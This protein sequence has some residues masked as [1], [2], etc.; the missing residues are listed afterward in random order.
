MRQGFDSADRENH[1]DSLNLRGEVI[2]FVAR[3]DNTSRELGVVLVR[4]GVSSM[5]SASFG[6]Y[7]AEVFCRVL[8]RQTCAGNPTV[9]LPSP[10]GTVKSGRQSDTPSLPPS[11]I[12]RA[13]L[14]LYAGCVSGCLGKR[15]IHSVSESHERTKQ[16]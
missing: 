16:R 13:I 5:D 9:W 4:G 10:Y 15:E 14:V 6:L 3:D 1:V 7:E 12:S 11:L 2:R 8:G